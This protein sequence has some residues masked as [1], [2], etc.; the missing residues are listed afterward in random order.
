M[1]EQLSV[2]HLGVTD[3]AHVILSKGHAAAMQYA[4]L[5][6]AGTLTREQLIA[7]KGGRSG[8]EAHAD[9]LMDTGLE[10]KK[11]ECGVGWLGLM[12]A[13]D[14]K[15]VRFDQSPGACHPFQE[16]WAVLVNC[17][18]HGCREP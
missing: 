2:L 8:L 16:S 5:Y 9:L 11:C 1:T 13:Q 14:K 3:A 6:A 7:Y 4:C 10:R 18:R 17:S 12:K 15:T